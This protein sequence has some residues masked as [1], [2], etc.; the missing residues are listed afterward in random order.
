MLRTGIRLP[1]RLLGIPVTLDPSFL[2]VL[3]LFAYL[4]GSQVPGLVT[5]LTQFGVIDPAASGAQLSAARDSLAQGSTPWVLGLAAA[6][7]LFTSVVIH[8]LGHAVVGRLYGVQTSE[9]RLWF[10]GGVAQFSEMPKQRGA[11]ALVALAGPVT[12]AAL[13][14]VSW[15]LVPIAAFSLGAQVVMAYVAVTNV[16]LA[17]F[18]LLPALP[19]DGGRVLRSLLALA[20]GR[21]RATTIAVTISAALAVLM[22]VY[23]FFTGQFFLVI[24]A[25]FVYNAGRA[26]ASAAYLDDAVGSLSVADLMTREPLTVQS[27]M[28]LAQFARLGQY[29]RH[30]GYPVVDDGALLGY[31]FLP[32]G[33]TEEGG[34]VVDVMQPAETASPTEPALGALQR[35]ASSATG[36][37]IV[38]DATGEVVGI[39]SKSDLIRVLGAVKR[40][41]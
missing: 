18:N 32:T 28:P 41:A 8:E 38:V 31:A 7:G 1:F 10:L 4:I 40:K 19:L 5:V 2:L 36:R 23:G 35:I 34:T 25:F 14:L 17:V 3:P 15:L 20:F 24:M 16:A 37:L 13:G 6:L 33:A 27:D 39:V 11:E 22:G 26:E 21:L 9:I 29:R 12:S 30:A